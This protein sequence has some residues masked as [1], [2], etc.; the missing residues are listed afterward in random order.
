MVEAARRARL[1]DEARCGVLFADEVRVDDLDRHG[2][3]EVRLLG[4]IDAP[5]PA[6]ADELEDEVS[7][8]QRAPDRADRPSSERTLPIGNPQD[9]QNRWPSSHAVAH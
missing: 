6:N 4:A 3:A 9:G 5:H 7:A 1:G 2:A 8:G